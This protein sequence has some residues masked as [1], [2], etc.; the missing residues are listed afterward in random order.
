MKFCIIVG[1]RPQIIKTQPI[2]Q[3]LRTRKKDFTIIHTGQHYDYDM[4]RT[5]FKELKIPKPDYNLGINKGSDTSQL[6]NLMRK[7]EILLTKITP[8]VVIVPGDTRSALGAA[9]C[10]NR[11]KLPLAHIEAGARSNDFE[12]EEEI[13]RRLIDHCSNFLFAPTKR[14]VKNLRNESTLGKIFDVG[15][16]MFDVFLKYKKSL[17]LK[18]QTR[19]NLVLMTLHRR[20]NISDKTK[21]KK[22]INLASD[23]SNQGFEVIFPIHPHTKKQIKN[24]KISLSDIRTVEPVNYSKT[25]SLLS[26]AKLLLT[27]S[28]GLQKEAYWTQ[29]PCFTFRKSTEWTETLATKSNQLVSNISNE[30]KKQILQILNKNAYSNKRSQKNLFGDGNSAKKIVSV[31]LKQF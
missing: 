25:L 24:Y 7:T 26:Q 30:T 2:I 13:N 29:T 5:F 20:E 21:L 17:G 14:C 18:K 31:L 4:S 28:G 11:L 16:T 6:A 3:E 22:I 15:D 19:K 1:T 27:D 8:D 12:L 10:A 9:L 23:I